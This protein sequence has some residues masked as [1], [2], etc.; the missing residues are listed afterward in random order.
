MD[1]NRLQ[2]GINWSPH[3]LRA[4]K[5][6]PDQ[7]N[8]A[9]MVMILQCFSLHLFSLR[10]ITVITHLLNFVRIIKNYDCNVTRASVVCLV[11]RLL[12]N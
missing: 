11:C 1:Y 4:Q 8:P 7:Q 6:R 10:F 3:K 12:Q 5:N 2:K 9:I